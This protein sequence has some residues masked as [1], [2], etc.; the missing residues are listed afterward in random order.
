MRKIIDFVSPFDG[1]P[2][3]AV[4]IAPSDVCPTPLP[5]VIVPHAA[6][7]SAE[8]TAAY[9]RDIPIRRGM[10]DPPPILWTPYAALFAAISFS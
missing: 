6:F 4:L 7:F 2:Q 8:K 5:L 3:K 9:W 10:I 1:S